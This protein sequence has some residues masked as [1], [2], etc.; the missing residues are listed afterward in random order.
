MEENLTNKYSNIRVEYKVCVYSDEGNQ[1]LDDDIWLLLKKIELLGSIK[2]TAEDSG[3]SYRKVW[4]DLKEIERVLGFPLITKT[5]GGEHGGNSSLTDEGRKFILA[6]DKLHTNIKGSVN[7]Y[8]I[9][10]KK[11]LKN[12]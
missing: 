5:R 4:G 1:I 11:T 8:I 2:A 10:F 12:K 3:I 6:F 9:E 7:D